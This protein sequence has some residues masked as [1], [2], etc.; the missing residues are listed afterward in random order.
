MLGN[1]TNC[2]HTDNI[3]LLISYILVISMYSV[4]YVCT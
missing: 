1:L 2:V 4:L 3:I